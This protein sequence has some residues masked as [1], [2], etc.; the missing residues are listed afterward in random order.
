MFPILILPI[1][2]DIK[3]LIRNRLSAQVLLYSS[4]GDVP[5]TDD[6][7]NLQRTFNPNEFALDAGYSRLLTDNFSGGIAFR[8]I[9]SNLTGGSYSG[10]IATKAGISF[11]ADVSG[12][13]QKRYSVFSVK[14]ANLVLVLI[15]RIS[16]QK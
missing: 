9:Y 14:M 7:G 5:F 4:L 8:F 16:D 15:S 10:G 12:Y 1:L 2:P 13:Y 11:A 6:F 3:E